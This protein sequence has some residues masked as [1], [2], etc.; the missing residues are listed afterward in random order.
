MTGL[1]VLF[2]YTRSFGV[3]KYGTGEFGDEQLSRKLKLDDV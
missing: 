1:V 2:F 3:V